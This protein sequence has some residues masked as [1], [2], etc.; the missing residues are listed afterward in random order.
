MEAKKV[1]GQGEDRKTVYAL[2]YAQTC[3]GDTGRNFQIKRKPQTLFDHEAHDGDDDAADST[4]D[5]Y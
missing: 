1:R 4:S 3:V 5:A 2:P